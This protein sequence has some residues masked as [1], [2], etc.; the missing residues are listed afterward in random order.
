[1]NTGADAG[2]PG[3]PCRSEKEDRGTRDLARRITRPIPGRS[4]RNPTGPVSAGDERAAYRCRRAA[5]EE[6]SRSTVVRSIGLSIEYRIS[7]SSA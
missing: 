6:T 3:R 4:G 5:I 7:K 1:M 2:P